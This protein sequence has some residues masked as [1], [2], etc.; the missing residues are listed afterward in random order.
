MQIPLQFRK[1]LLKY[2]ILLC[3]GDSQ[4][5]FKIRLLLDTTEGSA[6]G[7]FFCTRLHASGGQELL[8]MHLGFPYGAQASVAA[9]AKFN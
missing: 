6:F 8:L 5:P 3:I 7:S 1:H 9:L 4:L 2:F